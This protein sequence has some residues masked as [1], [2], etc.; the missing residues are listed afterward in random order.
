M[1][2][3]AQEKLAYLVVM[4]AGLKSA[5]MKRLYVQ[6]KQTVMHRK[7]AYMTNDKVKNLHFTNLEQVYLLFKPP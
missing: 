5:H 3:P 1:M 2:G 7:G 4:M 6:C